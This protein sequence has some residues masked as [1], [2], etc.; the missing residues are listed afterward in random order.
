[1][2]LAIS[3]NLPRFTALAS[4]WEVLFIAS[5]A[6]LSVSTTPSSFWRFCSSSTTWI[7]SFLFSFVSW[8]FLLDKNCSRPTGQEGLRFDWLRK[9]TRST[10]RSLLKVLWSSTVYQS[11]TVVVWW[12]SST[13]TSDD[14]ENCTCFKMGKEL[15][16]TGLSICSG[17]A[18]HGPDTVMRR[19][20]WWGDETGLYA[21]FG[22][23]V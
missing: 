17:G 6:N 11:S 9:E 22:L 5:S 7:T 23:V 19:L 21:V 14:S 18:V 2:N 15:R 1:M 4:S 20:F 12:W 13:Q 3:W 16:L 8:R 10:M